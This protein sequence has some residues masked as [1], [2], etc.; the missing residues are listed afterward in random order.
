MQ[1]EGTF[2]NVVT[3]YCALKACGRMTNINNGQKIHSETA[4]LG[5]ETATFLV[6]TLM[7]IYFKNVIYYRKHTM[8]SMSCL[9]RM[10]RHRMRLVSFYS[11]RVSFTLFL[12]YFSFYL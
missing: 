2:P 1:E 7:D 5:L 11:F 12:I 3:Y 10:W 6:V 8:F 4:N 9:Q